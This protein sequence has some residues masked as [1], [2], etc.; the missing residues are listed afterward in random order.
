MDNGPRTITVFAQIFVKFHFF[1][2]S[3][4]LLKF[5]CELTLTTT[6]APS[7]ED[8]LKGHIMS[9]HLDIFA[10]HF[11]GNRWKQCIKAPRGNPGHRG[12]AQAW[13]GSGGAGGHLFHA[14][15]RL[16]HPPFLWWAW[17]SVRICLFTVFAC[18]MALSVCTR[19]T[20]GD[21]VAGSTAWGLWAAGLWLLN[22]SW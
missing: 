7:Q 15:N 12:T 21:L 17:R 20:D 5:F 2:T 10:L 1:Y 19:A 22:K 4:I 16:Q 9:L 3:H 14:L 13:P 18:R 8:N 6:F 11:P